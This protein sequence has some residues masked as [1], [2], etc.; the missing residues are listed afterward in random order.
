MT[1]FC[2]H[3]NEPQMAGDFLTSWVTISF[4]RTLIHLVASPL[5]SVNTKA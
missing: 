1:S 5:S 4:W 3:G 2:E